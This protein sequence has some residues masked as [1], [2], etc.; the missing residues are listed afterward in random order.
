MAWNLSRDGLRGEERRIDPRA[1]RTPREVGERHAAEERDGGVTYL[2]PHVAQGAA[3]GHRTG[4][5]VVA[6]RAA[7]RRERALEQTH[8]PL[9]CDLLGILV[10]AI[11]ARGSALGA[12]DAGRPHRGHHL[13]Q[14]GLRHSGAPGELLELERPT[15]LAREREDRA[16][17]VVRPSRYPHR[18]DLPIGSRLTS[19]AEILYVLGH[20]SK[21]TI[22][23]E[24][25]NQGE[26]MRKVIGVAV[27]VGLLAAGLVATAGIG[28]AAPKRSVDARLSLVAY[29]TPR[30]AYGALIPAFQKTPE[31]D[32]VSFTQSYGASGD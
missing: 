22:L 6:R 4:L 5:G 25:L 31:G 2:L 28:S 19:N 17:R 1:A 27:A 23:V 8:D 30:A 13:L 24:K 9:E 3:D 32:G 15:P 21:L 29:S 14:H 7:D 10:E 12:D 18:S 26:A 16:R 11:A 20:F